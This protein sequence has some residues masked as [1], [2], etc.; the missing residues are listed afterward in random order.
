LEV[1]SNV[2]IVSSSVG[3]VAEF[4]FNALTDNISCSNNT[5]NPF[6]LSGE[7]AASDISKVDTV[8]SGIQSASNGIVSDGDISTG[9]NTS[10]SIGIAAYKVLKHKDVEEGGNFTKEG[11]GVGADISSGRRGNGFGGL[12]RRGRRRG[13]AGV[14]TARSGSEATGQGSVLTLTC[15][16]A[17]C[18][19]TGN[20]GRGIEGVVGTVLHDSSIGGS[21]VS[22]GTLVDTAGSESE[23]SVQIAVGTGSSL[24]RTGLSAA[25]SGK[26]GQRNSGAIVHL[27]AV[28]SHTGASVHIAGEGSEG[29][30]Q[31]TVGT[32][33]HFRRAGLSAG[34]GGGSV[35][36]LRL[37]VGDGSG[38]HDTV[39]GCDRAA[40][41]SE[42]STQ[43]ASGHTGADFGTAG[44]SA[45]N[46]GAF[47]VGLL[48]SLGLSTVGGSTGDRACL[49]SAGK[50]SERS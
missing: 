13:V 3:H 39:T 14:N 28:G 20:S 33:S 41:G 46:I 37:T 9:G 38:S 49:G 25:D 44:G 30:I 7:I 32:F 22:L 43:L 40:G 4:D 8:L 21:T 34:Y 23:G 10:L 6:T 31:L 29:S 47:V 17:A 36:F 15:L 26:L 19:A 16:K 27:L 2:V 18:G 1:D 12:G 45:G 50:L 5:G 11:L 24:I 42:T 48:P 35:V